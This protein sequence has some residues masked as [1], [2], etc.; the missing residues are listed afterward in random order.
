MVNISECPI[1]QGKSYL[2]EMWFRAN[3][4]A[5]LFHLADGSFA[6][7]I[8][9]GSLVVNN[10]T[11]PIRN[12]QN[13][14]WHHLA[15]IN[16]KIST[17]IVAIDGAQLASPS[18]QTL[19]AFASSHIILGGAGNTND[20]DIDE[21]RLWNINTTLDATKLLMG[22]CLNGEESGLLAYYPMEAYVTDPVSSQISTEFSLADKTDAEGARVIT[23]SDMANAQSLSVP[24]LVE[25]RPLEYVAHTHTTSGDRIMVNITE[26]AQRIEGCWLEI[27]V[28]D[29]VDANGNYSE[30]IRWTVF[31]NR[32]QLLWDENTYTIVKDEMADTT[33]TLTIVNNSSV[34]QSWNIDNLPSCMTMSET[35]GRIQPLQTKTISCTIDATADRGE[36]EYI[37]YLSGNENMDCPLYVTTKVYA[38]K[39]DWNINPSDYEHSMNIIAFAEVDGVVADD[40]ED[41]V[42]AFVDGEL[43]GV[44]NLQL[45]PAMGRYYLMMTIFQNSATSSSPRNITFRYWDASTGL[46]YSNARVYS[47]AGQLM[48]T[49]TYQ[50]NIALGD[51]ADPIRLEMGNEIEQTIEVN[52]G[53]NWISFNVNP[54]S[55]SF[56]NILGENTKKFAIIKSQ[57]GYAVP[58]T[59][60]HRVQ[61]SIGNMDCRLGYKLRAYSAF[62]IQLDGMAAPISTVIDLTA[63]QWTWFGFIPQKAMTVNTAMSNI[64][65]T[66]GDFIK[67][68]TQFASWDGYQ[69]VGSLKVMQP[70]QSYVYKNKSNSDIQLEY[71]EYADVPYLMP[72]Q[73]AVVSEYFT[74]VETG[75]YQGNMNITAVVKYEGQEV[76]TAEIGVF[77]EDECRAAATCDGGYYFI[78]VPGDS[79]LNLSMKVVYNDS[80][81]TLQGNLIY[82]NDAIVGT[83]DAPYVIDL[84]S[85]QINDDPGIGNDDPGEEPLSVVSVEAVNGSK[86]EKVL[87]DNEVFIIKD[88]QM[89]D[90]LGRKRK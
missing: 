39:P 47:A 56:D 29:I 90:A 70:G 81:Y 69:W 71:P 28:K 7:S 44:A 66:I 59:A 74:P 36:N 31:V 51:I 77:A 86:V 6:T 85:G 89:Y 75:K 9:N 63:Q 46:V 14:T 13:N 19:P 22:N 45:L 38:N 48:S 83:L 16:P 62:D 20:I 4:N 80:L 30:P 55:L 34:I 61:G 1:E 87:I 32:N 67:S 18:L 43:A 52:R 12:Y 78:T 10:H 54:A 25:S 41:M 58:D 8:V 11:L 64:N 35:S 84:T 53:W 37:L 49:L 40:E 73:Y 60:N 88:G 2:Y 68:Q 3:G 17:P 26:P 5:E 57:N 82:R 76:T 21:V 24:A 79:S 15:I 42:A 27:M 50:D 33:F 65:P 72:A 23:H